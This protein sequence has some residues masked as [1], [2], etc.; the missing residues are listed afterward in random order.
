[1][2]TAFSATLQTYRKQFGSSGWLVNLEDG[3][4]T[5]GSWGGGAWRW[6][7]SVHSD[8]PSPALLLQRIQ[9]ELQ[10]S[11]TSLKAG[12][13]VQIF[14]HAPAFEHL[15]FGELRGVQFTFLKTEHASAGAKYAFALMGKRA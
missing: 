3:R 4:L 12:Q 9:Q 2:Q 10:L 13:P 14:V 6:I 8:L 1:V 11:S 7:Y 15:P 5:L